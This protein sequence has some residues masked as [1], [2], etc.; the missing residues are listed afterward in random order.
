ML[1]SFLV[2]LVLTMSGC[3][4]HSV[5]RPAKVWFGYV[6]ECENDQ[7]DLDFRRVGAYYYTLREA[8]DAA[9]IISCE[10]QCIIMHVEGQVQSIWKG[11][12]RTWTFQR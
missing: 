7:L 1:R 4:A 9:S 3:V 2:A 11:G 8:T 6:M 10:Y 5:H 12:R